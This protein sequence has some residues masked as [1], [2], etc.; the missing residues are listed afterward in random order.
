MILMH[1]NRHVR[2]GLNRRLNQMAQKH[3]TG[4]FSSA[5]RCLHDDR[6]VD[7]RSRSHDGLHLLQVI[8]IERW[9]P[10]ASLSGVVQQLA[11]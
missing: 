3:F 7:F 11:H 1:D 6:C 9:N 5:G 4:I 8:D 2:I 10:V